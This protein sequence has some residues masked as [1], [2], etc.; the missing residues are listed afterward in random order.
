V[1][2]VPGDLAPDFI[3]DSVLNGKVESIS[4]SS[5]PYDDVATYGA[6]RVDGNI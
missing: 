4:R 2:L 3:L 5:D 1:D 6:Y